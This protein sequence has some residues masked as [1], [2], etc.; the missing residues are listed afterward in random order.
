MQIMKLR[1]QASVPGLHTFRITEDGLQAF[2][3]TLGLVGQRKTYGT[4][5][6]LSMGIPALDEMMGGGVP[7][8]DSL[9]IAG[10]SGT[11]KSLI[12]TQFLAAGISAGE[13]GIAAVFEERPNEYTA[14]AS[15]FGL[16][17]QT[18]LTEGRLE[19]IYLRPLDLSVDEMM[20]EI[21]D[22]VKRTGAKR[23]VIDSLAG[24]E[25]ALAPSF[26]T[27]FRESLYRMIFALTAIGIT[28]LSTLEMPE[29]FTELSFSSYSI[30]FLTDDIIRMRYVEIDGELCQIMMVVKMRRT[31]HSREIRKYWITTDGIVIGDRLKN[32]VDL[33]TGIPQP[34]SALRTE[35]PLP[36]RKV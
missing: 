13:P 31:A 1:G 15:E 18:P 11:G 24:F 17:L 2:S 12:A 10:S 33:I 14:R 32:Y 35:E 8:G 9:L 20:Q 28:I 22:A 21:L 26:R 27:D 3:R 23:L 36:N 30:S 34:L 6:R 5:R 29:T 4:A 19:V 16:D 25:M 7:E